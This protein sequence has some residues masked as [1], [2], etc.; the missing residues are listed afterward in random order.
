[1]GLLHLQNDSCSRFKKHIE[2]CGAWVFSLE[3]WE[4]EEAGYL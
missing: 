3:T 4:A 1:M 2:R